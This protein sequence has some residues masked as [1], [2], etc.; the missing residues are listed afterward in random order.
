MFRK[1]LPTTNYLR[2]SSRCYQPAATENYEYGT[3]FRERLLAE[4]VFGGASYRAFN[5]SKYRSTSWR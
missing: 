1:A 5:S 2:F 3:K 4:E